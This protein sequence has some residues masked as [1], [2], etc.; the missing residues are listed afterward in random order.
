MIIGSDGAS[1]TFES[2]KRGDVLSVYESYDG[3]YAKIY[4]SNTQISEKLNVVNIS[5]RKVK[6]GDEVLEF[7]DGDAKTKFNDINRYLGQ[8]IT[9]LL[10]IKVISQIMK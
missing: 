6:I 10:D 3:K 9:V 2:V 1:A 7:Y 8:K 4:I 5:E